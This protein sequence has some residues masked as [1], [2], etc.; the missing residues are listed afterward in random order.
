M[1]EFLGLPYASIALAAVIPAALYF[2]GVFIAIDFEARK[3]GIR[4]LAR[5]EVPSIRRT[6]TDGWFYFL[7]IALIIYLLAEGYTPML[8]VVYSAFMVLGIFILREFILNYMKPAPQR[9]SIPRVLWHI[10]AT[11]FSAFQDG[12]KGAVPVGLA[13]AS[14]GIIVGVVTM[15]GLGFKIGNAAVAISGGNLFPILLMTMITSLILGMG[16]PTTAN[17]IIT[18]TI[19]APAILTFM[20]GDAGMP[21]RDFITAHPEAALSAHMFA[22]YFGVAADLT[23]PVALAA[24]ASAAIARANPMKTGYNA[25][26][27]GLGTYVVPFLFVYSPILLLSG[28]GTSPLSWLRLIGMVIITVIAMMSLNAGTIGYTFGKCGVIARVGFITAGVLMITPSVYA[29]ATGVLVY[30]VFVILQWRSSRVGK[31]KAT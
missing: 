2:A 17:Y 11:I 9:R 10:I 18:A 7:P 3:F 20:A 31:V 4:G 16:I 26:I 14:A 5:E 22:F 6:I 8:S 25:F 1:A 27:V 30:L 19:A 12:G 23:P 29:S 15:T 21:V 24:Y 13:C 28:L